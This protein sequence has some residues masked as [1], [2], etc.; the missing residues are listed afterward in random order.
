VHDE[1][2]KLCVDAGEVLD[3]GVAVR[4]RSTGQSGGQLSSDHGG[5]IHGLPVVCCG[6]GGDPHVAGVVDRASSNVQSRA[7]ADGAVALGMSSTL[8]AAL[9]GPFIQACRERL[10]KVMVRFHISDSE[11]LKS[12]ISTHALDLALSRP[13]L[14]I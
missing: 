6:P 2:V 3:G 14:P 8:A 5:Q 9:G 7:I 11:T 12:E 1:Q 13:W 10:P 4:D